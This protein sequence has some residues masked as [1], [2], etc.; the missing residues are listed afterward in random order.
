MTQ[1]NDTIKKHAHHKK[2]ITRQYNY[3]KKGKTVA[4]TVLNAN[5]YAIITRPLIL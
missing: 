5:Q 3:S 2:R 4:K 1:E